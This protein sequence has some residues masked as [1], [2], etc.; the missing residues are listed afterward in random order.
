MHKSKV[1]AFHN[2]LIILVYKIL[3]LSKWPELV[4]IFTSSPPFD[5]V[6]GREPAE[7]IEIA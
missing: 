5:T 1:R 4:Q 3:L 6:S 7:L 2:L